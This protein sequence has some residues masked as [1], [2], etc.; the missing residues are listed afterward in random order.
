MGGCAV[1]LEL[2]CGHCGCCGVIRKTE[3]WE[4]RRLR[5]LLHTGGGDLVE[6]CF[7]EFTC[8]AWLNVGMQ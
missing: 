3:S 7:G 5:A 2:R 4:V 6:S 1:M 8:S